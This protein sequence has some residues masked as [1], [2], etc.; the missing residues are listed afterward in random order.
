MKRIPRS[1]TLNYSEEEQRIIDHLNNG[2]SIVVKVAGTTFESLE[3]G[4]SRQDILGRLAED[5][6]S[7]MSI[8]LEKQLNNPY[9]KDAV[10]V[11]ISTKEDIGFIPRKGSVTLEIPRGKRILHGSISCDRINVI[12]RRM[13]LSGEIM[14]ITGGFAGGSYGVNLILHKLD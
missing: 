9:D 3:T 10:C 7:D 11:R 2:G 14:E 4:E 6:P 13:N 8:T 12:L 5:P 1:T